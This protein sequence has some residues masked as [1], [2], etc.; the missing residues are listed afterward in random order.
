MV[1]QMGKGLFAIRVRAAVWR[2]SYDV[3]VIWIQIEMFVRR[4][5]WAKKGVECERGMKI[6]VLV[7]FVC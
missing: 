7:Y 6:L 2:K 4:K 1:S 5:V 3:R